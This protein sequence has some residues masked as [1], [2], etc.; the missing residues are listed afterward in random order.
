MKIGIFINTPA[1]AYFFKN[2]IHSLEEKGN[3]VFLLARDYGETLSILN[4]ANDKYFV[5]N[6]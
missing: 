6:K 5:F 3:N 2:I 1:Q 4:S